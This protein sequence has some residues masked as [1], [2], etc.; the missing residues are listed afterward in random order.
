MTGAVAHLVEEAL[1]LSNESRIELV[2]A[3][4]ERSAP[5]KEFVTQQMQTILERMDAVREGRSELVPEEEAHRRVRQA[6]TA[7]S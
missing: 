4:L 3:L 2:E 6:L 1:L 5:S 7:L